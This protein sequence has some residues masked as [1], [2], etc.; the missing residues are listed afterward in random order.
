MSALGE[1]AF[2]LVFPC[3]LLSRFDAEAR[4]AFNAK[5]P[6]WLDALSS[7]NRFAAGPLLRR[8][9]FPDRSAGTDTSFVDPQLKHRAP[10][11][12]SSERGRATAKRGPVAVP[13]KAH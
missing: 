2:T 11:S 13:T 6:R 12:G 7:A 10:I 4:F 5:A 1:R 9:L 8:L 3:F